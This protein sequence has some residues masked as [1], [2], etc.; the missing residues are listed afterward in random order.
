MAKI[1]QHRSGRTEDR[2]LPKITFL[3]SH[4]ERIGNLPK[5]TKLRLEAQRF[6]TPP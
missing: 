3:I 5:I 1:P 6:R 4:K 2:Q